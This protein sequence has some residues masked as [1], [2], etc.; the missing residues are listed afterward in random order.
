VGGAL[1]YPVRATGHY[2]GT[3]A[4]GMRAQAIDRDGGKSAASLPT[5]P[6]QVMSVS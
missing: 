2:E 4:A 1:A 5:T 6:Q 3:L